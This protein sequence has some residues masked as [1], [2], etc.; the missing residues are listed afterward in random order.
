MCRAAIAASL[1][2]LLKHRSFV[3][4]V[5]ISPDGKRILTVSFDNKNWIAQ[6]FQ[7]PVEYGD[8]QG[9]AMRSCRGGER[10]WT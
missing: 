8:L 7:V 10:I 4:S 3:D 6:I 1:L 9:F 5:A 2:E